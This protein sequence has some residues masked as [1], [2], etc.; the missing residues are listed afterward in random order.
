MGTTTYVIA[1]LCRWKKYRY[2]RLPSVCKFILRGWKTVTQR[3]YRRA[4]N[5]TISECT[6]PICRWKCQGTR[7]LR[8]TGGYK[9]IVLQERQGSFA[10]YFEE[11]FEVYDPINI[12]LFEV[13]A[14][15]DPS[16]WFLPRACMRACVLAPK[17]YTHKVSN[18]RK[19]RR[20]REKKLHQPRTRSTRRWS[21]NSSKQRDSS[22]CVPY[23]AYMRC[24][25]VRSP[26]RKR[27]GDPLSW[28]AHASSVSWK[29]IVL[30]NIFRL[31][32][33]I[34]YVNEE[35]KLIAPKGIEREEKIAI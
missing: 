19:I 6:L 21:K 27:L 11:N 35:G 16:P 32:L 34:S 14:E 4:V 22:S 17:V 23:L 9:L 12:G 15:T 25:R 33:F 7:Y 26:T 29:I 8:A 24:T 20:G 18:P 5:E 30:T 2:D 10:V 28:N 1:L 3:R 13:D 31:F